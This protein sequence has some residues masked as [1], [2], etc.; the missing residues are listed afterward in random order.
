L[1]A[2]EPQVGFNSASTSTWTSV[3]IPLRPQPWFCYKLLKIRR[4]FLGM[5]GTDLGQTLAWV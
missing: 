4:V 5:L 3:E 1:V 2:G